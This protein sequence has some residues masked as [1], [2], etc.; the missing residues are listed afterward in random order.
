MGHTMHVII[1]V[2]GKIIQVNNEHKHIDILPSTNTG[3]VNDHWRLCFHSTFVHTG[4]GDCVAIPLFYLYK[5]QNIND[6]QVIY[7]ITYL[8]F[9]SK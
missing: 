6:K 5:I 9:F 3:I 4:T 7:F 1:F 8:L 2:I